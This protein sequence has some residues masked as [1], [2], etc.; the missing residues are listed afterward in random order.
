[1][2]LSGHLAYIQP[3]RDFA[4]NPGSLRENA[5]TELAKGVRSVYVT[6]PRVVATR[7]VSVFHI[8]MVFRMLS[9]HCR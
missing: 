2:T 4:Y 5:D 9:I 1:M 7:L 3:W 8:E 6:E